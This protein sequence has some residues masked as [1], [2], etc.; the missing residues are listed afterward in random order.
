MAVSRAAIE[1]AGLLDESLFA[2]AEDTEWSPADPR[3]GLR[4]RLRAGREG[5]ARRLGVDRRDA[6]AD[7]H[8]LRHAQHD[9]RRRASRSAQRRGCGASGGASSL[10]AHLANARDAA[11]VRAARE[12]LARRAAG[13]ARDGDDER[14]GFYERVLRSSSS[15]SRAARL[16][17]ARGRRRRGRPRGVRG[18]RVHGR[19]VHEPGRRRRRAAGRGGAHLR[20]RHV[21]LRRHLGGAA[22]LRVAASCAA[23][24]VPRRAA[25]RPRAGERATRR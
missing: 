9:R 18:V 22:P 10:G 16:A 14:I 13:E 25:R 5:V 20:R 11:G 6:L 7:E 17:R 15:G 12:G 3:G 2:Y 21:R 19:H 8:L 4:R 24:A 1:R 23:R